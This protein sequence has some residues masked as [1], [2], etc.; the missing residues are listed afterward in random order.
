MSDRAERKQV[1]QGNEACAVGAL[2]AGVRFFGGYPITPSSEIAEVMA[3]CLPLMGGRF[4]QME[5]EIASIAAI[6]GASLAGAKAMTA[7]SGPGFSLMQE[8][9]GFAAMA[10]IPCVIVNVQRAGPS[11]GLPTQ[12]A[13]ADVQQT[14]WGTHG[15]HS[16]IALAPSSVLE[17]FTMTIECVNLSER[18][19]TPAVLLSD[20]VVGH[21]RESVTLPAPGD[22]EV[23]Y[24]SQLPSGATDYLPYGRS[25]DGELAPLAAFGDEHRFHVTGLTHDQ[26][27]FPT[28]VKSEVD[29]KIRGI[30][31]K[32]EGR[33]D[34]LARYEE[35]MTE[36]AD[37][38]LFAYGSTARVAKSSVRD[39][40]SRGI[41][42]GLLRAKTI[43]PFSGAR[44]RELADGLSLVVVPEMNLGQ[45]SLEV[46]RALCGGT[47]VRAFGKVDGELF[48]PGEITGF[49]MEALGR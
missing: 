7:T 6:V 17:C 27:G 23:V 5:D 35:F 45:M 25:A 46:E 16:I 15:D 42:A 49:T 39:L 13:Q 31:D 18:Y 44:L 2:A 26:R 47:D 30:F 28:M 10:E 36:D 21:M 22:Y 41:R 34:E 20:E 1:L 40:R 12:P 29:E 43:W 33:A 9:I 11:T 38:L 19:R 14:R 4:I 37:V 32:I 8:N 24:R 3:Q 48:T